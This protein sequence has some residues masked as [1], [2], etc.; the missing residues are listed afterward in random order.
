MR[1]V[2]R[3]GPPCSADPLDEPASREHRGVNGARVLKRD[4]DATC[5]RSQREEGR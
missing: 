1:E 5:D 3:Q 2:A 4:G